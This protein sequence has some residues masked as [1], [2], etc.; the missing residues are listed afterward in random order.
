MSNSRIFYAIQGLGLAEH[1]VIA[2][3][4]APSGFRTAHGV[5]SVGVN[6]TF[7]LEQVFELGQL[8]LYENIEGI[9]AGPAHTKPLVP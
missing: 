5:Q 2:S 1:G 3:G 7:N 9:P 4:G 8:E 6:T